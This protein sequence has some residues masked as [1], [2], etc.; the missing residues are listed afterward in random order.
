MANIRIFPFDNPK[1]AFAVESVA[2]E[3]DELELEWDAQR[4]IRT[5]S[6]HSFNAYLISNISGTCDMWLTSRSNSCL[7]ILLIFTRDKNYYITTVF[8]PGIILVTSA[9]LGFWLDKGDVSTRVTIG[10]TSM[11]SYC[12][13]MI[14]FRS[15]LPV[16]SNLEA[17]NLWDGACLFFI[18]TSFVEYIVV[19]YLYRSTSS[20]T[21]SDSTMHCVC[22]ANDKNVEEIED[23][24][25]KTDAKCLRIPSK[26]LSYKIERAVRIV[27][28]IS[29]GAFVC[30]YIIAFAIV[31]PSRQNNFYIY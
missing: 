25:E 23:K 26:E 20:K 9:F 18:Y 8:L 13:T 1:C 29:F 14:N 3:Q 21:S 10:V 22:S 11:L 4:L 24:K 28:P 17:M 27:F 16:V 31:F 30:Y 19:N 12:T 6:F 15:S 2:L 5:T 7:Y